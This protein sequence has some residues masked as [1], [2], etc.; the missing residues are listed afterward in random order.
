MKRRIITVLLI[1]FICIC[2]LGSLYGCVDNDHTTDTSESQSPQVE[3]DTQVESDDNTN[4][5]DNS[6]SET[7]TNI[8]LSDVIYENGDSILQA[9]TQWDDSVFALT[10]NII[11]E[12]KAITKTAAELLELL[13][14]KDA[15]GEGDVYRVTEPLILSSGTKYYGNLASIIAEGGIFIKDASEVVIK[16]IIIKGNVT[17]ENST[18]ITFF[19]LDL[20]G[21]DTGVMI[22]DKSSDIAFK[23]C[24]VS[25]TDIAIRS[26]ADFVT[27]Y[28]NYISANHGIVSQGDDLT[29]QDSHIVVSDLGVSSVGK[30]CTVR[31][32]TIEADTRGLGVELQAGS[33][34]SLVALNL[35]KNVQGSVKAIDG[36]NSVLL[37]NS[38]IRIIGEGNTNLYVV[39]NKLGG[40]IEL[41]N[42]KYLLCDGNSFIKDEKDHPIVS[43]GNTEFNG[44]NLHD[45][46]ARVEY[47]ANEELL[48]HTNKDLFV[49]M[50]R[51]DYVA[52]ASITKKYDFNT[53]VS[54]LGRNNSIVIIPPGVYTISAE[55]ELDASHS[56]LNIY[57]YGVYAEKDSLGGLVETNN[58]S[59]LNINGLTLG[60]THQSSG[61][62]YVLDKLGQNRI[63]VVTNA[64]YIDDFGASNT[65]VFS[66]TAGY[67]YFKGALEPW[68]NEPPYR[69][70]QK[71]DDGTMVLELTG[72][73][74]GKYYGSIGVGDIWVCRLAGENFRSIYLVNSSDVLLK[75]CVLYGYSRALGVVASGRN[76]KGILLERFHNTAHS[77]YEID[78]ETYEKYE[79]LEKKYGADLEIYMDS[80]GRYRGGLPRVGSV[81]A[82]H[83]TRAAQGASATSCLFDFMCDDGSNQHAGSSRVAGYHDNGD[84][85]VTVYFKGSL[86]KVYHDKNVEAGAVSGSPTYMELPKSGD[87]LFAYASNGMTAISG[88]ALSD[89]VKVSGSPLYHIYHTDADKNCICDDSSCNAMLHLDIA[90]DSGAASMNGICDTCKN[91]VY[92]DTNSDGVHDLD[93]EVLLIDENHDGL[94][95]ADLVPII[96]SMAV[97]EKYDPLTSRLTFNINYGKKIITYTTTLYE[98][99]VQKGSINFEAFEEYDLT[100]NDY[101]MDDKVIIDNISLNTVGFT[102]DNVMIAN[103]ISRGILVKTRD[104][105]IKNCT[106][107]NHGMTAILLSVE[108]NWGEST[109][110]RNV[111]I[112]G[113]LFDNTGCLESEKNNFKMAPIAIQGLGELS[114]SIEISKDTLPAQNIT[115]TGN[116]FVNISN[117]YCITMSAVQNVTVRNNIFVE[118]PGETNKKVGKAIYISGCMDILLSDNTYSSFANGDITQVVIAHNYKGLD[119]NDVIDDDGNRLMPDE[120]D[121]LE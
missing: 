86:A 103:S 4:S 41:E 72:K 60:Y 28:R 101:F 1:F 10:D 118:R 83:I 88:K 112:E 78:K 80:E 73:N 121:A 76:S 90:T 15:V 104:A 82:T 26:N 48:P 61:Q 29:V 59:K 18:G 91:P 66:A 31:N 102:F 54:T 57:A 115:I 34:N 9:G 69:F 46:S 22:D 53:Y 98:V 42:N 64:G 49:G 16:E 40:A 14:K 2:S 19:K 37:L 111:S 62:V 108:T 45:V 87:T 44:S 100:D 70:V 119:G 74:A 92:T 96:T 97:N 47:G 3:S 30:T 94:N 106:F 35:I 89:A 81:D 24:K 17:V 93:K 56:G 23:N 21:G 8:D 13:Q 58:I 20:K 105:T 117:N 75:D 5:E 38:A 55:L 33:Y 11:D 85:T 109:V 107:R 110:P 39:E 77:S 114:N 63:L 71:N 32:N 52:D 84:G 50:E 12:S 68:L 6:E 95:D 113:C 67:A 65:S 116:K 27:V 43:E 51:K 120:K 99:K 79:A 7:E 36:Y 25:A